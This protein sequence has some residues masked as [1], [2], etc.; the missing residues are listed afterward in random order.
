M[1]QQAPGEPCVRMVRNMTKRVFLSGNYQTV[2]AYA[3]LALPYAIAAV[4]AVEGVWWALLIAFAVSYIFYAMALHRVIRV[5]VIKNGRIKA[6]PSL[7]PIDQIQHKVDVPLNDIVTA[8]YA[9]AQG[10]SEG[11]PI[12]RTWDIPS[13]RIMLRD[14][15]EKTIILCGYT[16]ERIGSLEKAMKQGNRSIVFKNQ[17]KL[18]FGG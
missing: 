13:L 7:T 4:A 8:T 1:G 6:F 5:I 14:G 17:S 9:F 12:P 10:D 16:K 11:N 18:F 15:R 3:F 2:I